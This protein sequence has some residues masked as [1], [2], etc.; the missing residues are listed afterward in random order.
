MGG[1]L[2]MSVDAQ[3]SQHDFTVHAQR[4]FLPK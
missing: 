1:R 2:G 3:P 4:L